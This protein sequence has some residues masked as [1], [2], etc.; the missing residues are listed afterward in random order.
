[1][2]DIRVIC[3]DC[4]TMDVGFRS[5]LEAVNAWQHKGGLVSPF[6]GEAVCPVCV[7]KRNHPTNWNRNTIT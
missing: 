1:M 7:A 2:I 5:R 3:D 6:S 4:G